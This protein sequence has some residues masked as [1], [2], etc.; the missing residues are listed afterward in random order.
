MADIYARL[1]AYLDRLPAGYPPTDSGVELKILR[2]LFSPEEAALAMHLT[3]FGEEARVIAFR[4]H[5]PVEK[6]T[7][8]LESM[9]ER[10]LISSDRLPARPL[11]SANQF[12]VGFLEGQAGHLDRELAGLFEEYQADFEK[13]GPW[14]KVLPQVRTVPVGV[15]IPITTE[16]LH[17]ERAEEILR[18][19]TDFA[20]QTCACRDHAAVMGR[21][22]DNP[23]DSCMLLGPSA[24]NAVNAGRARKL[25]MDEALEVLKMAEEKGLVLQPANSQNPI[26]I[27]TCCSCC[28]GI[29]DMLKHQEKPADFVLNPF[30]AKHNDDTCSV[31]GTCAER[32]PMNALTMDGVRMAHNPDRCIGCG[33]CVST[34]PSGSMTMIRKPAGETPS[35]PKNTVDTYLRLGQGRDPL[36]IAKMAGVLV[37]SK[38]EHV[39]APR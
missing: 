39:I 16:V 12:V 7:R 37:R 35:I 14:F 6:V 23:L 27:C 19:N 9:E 18:R 11:F 32:C 1:A 3:L 24:A 17:Y 26:F 22:C 28:C 20:V 36:F 33:L 8:M 5:Q 2:K 34:C 31:C 13:K 25:S 4:A 21:R 38:I 30:I 29:L 15:S 10:G